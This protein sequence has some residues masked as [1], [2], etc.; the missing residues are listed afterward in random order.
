MRLGPP[1]SRP[2]NPTRQLDDKQKRIEIL[3]K[4]VQTKDEVLAEHVALKTSLGGALTQSWV[5][6]DVRDLVVDFVRHWAENTEISPGQF[7]P[8]LGVAVTSSM[9]AGG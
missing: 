2:K 8:W 3:E 1:L 5:A 4:K 9:T 6:H 7:L